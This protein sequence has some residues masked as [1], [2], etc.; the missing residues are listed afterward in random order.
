MR[1]KAGLEY[2]AGN[3]VYGLVPRHARATLAKA[4]KTVGDQNE[5]ELRRQE[6]E[7]ARESFRN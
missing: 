3:R 4:M 1:G 7:S 5:E 2:E 6:S